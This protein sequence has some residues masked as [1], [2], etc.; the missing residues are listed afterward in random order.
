MMRMQWEKRDSKEKLCL[1]DRKREAWVWKIYWATWRFGSFGLKSFG[2]LLEF[3]GS[4]PVA[5]LK[6]WSSCVVAASFP[7]WIGSGGAAADPASVDRGVEVPLL[8]PSDEAAEAEADLREDER[9]CE[10]DVMGGRCRDLQKVNSDSSTNRLIESLVRSMIAS[11]SV[12]EFGFSSSVELTF[13]SSQAKHLLS[14]RFASI[15]TSCRLLLEA[16][17]RLPRRRK[18]VVQS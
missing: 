7:G 12:W 1:F 3:K 5:S 8:P 4:V 15:Q 17:V 16:L 18:L 2:L 13:V 11:P 9:E 6:F 14:L 10:K